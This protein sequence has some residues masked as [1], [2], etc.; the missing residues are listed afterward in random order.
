MFV[1]LDHYI[2][3]NF[4][5]DTDGKLCGI[6]YPGYSYIYFTSPTDMVYVSL[7]QTERVC[8][9][10]CPLSTDTKLDCKAT[11]SR[12]CRYNKDPKFSVSYYPNEAVTG[13]KLII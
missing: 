9:S 8:V 5:A 3:A 11:N 2:K 7:I 1:I 4:P 10:K 12:G 6:D 13:K